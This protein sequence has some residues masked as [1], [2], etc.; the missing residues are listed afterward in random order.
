MIAAEM[1][2]QIM[3]GSI[4]HPP[5]FTISSIYARFRGSHVRHYNRAP[6]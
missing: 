5:D 2:E 1:T 4:N 3:M 6:E